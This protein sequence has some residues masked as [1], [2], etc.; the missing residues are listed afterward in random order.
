MADLTSIATTGVVILLTMILYLMSA[1]QHTIV[2]PHADCIA[3][4]TLLIRRLAI[5]SA[6]IRANTGTSSTVQ[7]N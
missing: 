5:S 6:C 3:V 7:D 4:E 2:V 1:V